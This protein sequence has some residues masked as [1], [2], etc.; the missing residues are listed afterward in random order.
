MYVL[1]SLQGHDFG[2]HSFKPDL[3]A[4]KI[5]LFLKIAETIYQIL[6]QR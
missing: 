5:F 1:Q 3:E 2:S 6:D 4:S